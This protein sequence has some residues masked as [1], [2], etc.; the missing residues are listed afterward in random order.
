AIMPAT[1]GTIA[2]VLIVT[3]FLFSAEVA[4]TMEGF[5]ALALLLAWYSASAVERAGIG[6]LMLSLILANLGAAVLLL[7]YLY[8][9][10]AHGVPPTPINSPVAYSTDLVNFV[11]PTPTA[12]IGVT[13]PLKVITERFSGNFGEAGGYIA[14]PLLVIVT[15]YARAHWSETVPRLLLLMLAIIAVAELGPRLHIAGITSFG[16]PWK[17]VTHV[18]LLRN[19]LPARFS[20]YASLALALIVAHWLSFDSSPAWLRWVL[21]G[22]FA[23]LS[24]PNLA[25][26]AF[27]APTDT[28]NFFAAGAYRRYLRP[29]QIVIILPYGI[30]GNSM[31]W[32]AQSGMYFRM[33]G[34]RSAITPR[35]FE[36]WPIVN[37]FLTK[38]YVPDAADQ[39]KAFSAAHEVS[40]ILVEASSNDLWAPLL[41]AIDPA[42][43]TV[44]GMV[45]YR[46]PD[47][48]TYDGIPAAEMERRADEARFDALVRGT[49]TYLANG[50]DSAKLSPL[51]LQTRGLLPAHWVRDADM[52]TKNG[53][54]LGP[55]D[56][57]A[58]GIGVVGSYEALQPLIK[59]YRPIA[60]KVYFPY[61][62]ELASPPHGDTFMRLLVIAFRPAALAQR[63]TALR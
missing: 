23:V 49:R 40:A 27:I 61:P 24:L 41:T 38:T 2:T 20:M 7:P 12:L 52:R 48:T 25:A 31:Q 54:F 59:R 34:G 57:H 28:P 63:P 35:E 50:G 10:F 14:L 36:A 62:K 17:L 16:L 6:K 19:A 30:T 9:M 56:G 45:I 22:S 29:N 37:A 32:L 58:I 43:K 46:V 42:P 4:A 47:L 26:G 21:I 53:L 5:A 39:L 33:A 8:S 60:G 51:E 44:D 3:Q 55:L 15:L 1:F 13:A 11:V 18:P